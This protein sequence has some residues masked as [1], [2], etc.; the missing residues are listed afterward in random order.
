MLADDSNEPQN[1]WKEFEAEHREVQIKV[2]PG[3]LA[4]M[5]RKRERLNA[6]VSWMAMSVM[7]L[8]AA[9]FLYNVWSSEKPWMRFGQAWMFGLLAYAVGAAFKKGSVRKG[10]SE[11]CARFLERQHEER[12][13]GYLRIRSRLWLV[14][15]GVVASWLGGGAALWMFVLVCVGLVL[16]WFAFGAAAAKARRDGEEL[17]GEVAG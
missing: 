14:I 12:A 17:R 15:P 3:A 11:P 16:V 9:G 5:V 13:N 10:V 2:E 1:V 6:F 7:I 8:L 4:A